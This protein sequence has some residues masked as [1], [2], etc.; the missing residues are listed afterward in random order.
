MTVGEMKNILKDVADD[1]IV[2]HGNENMD[3]LDFGNPISNVIKVAGVSKDKFT[4]LV[5]ISE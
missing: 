3:M 4:Y 5:I 1:V 2:T